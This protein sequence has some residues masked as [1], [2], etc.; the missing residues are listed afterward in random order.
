MSIDLSKMSRADLVQLRKDVETAIIVAES[1]ER[2]EAFK[3]VQD[4]A[5]KFGY[6]LDELTN[7]GKSAPKS[8]G[9]SAPKFRNPEDPEQTWSGLGRKPKWVHDAIANGTN[10]SD[11]EI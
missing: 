9:R 3:A 8:R 7:T 11:L 10:M 5:A 2:K 6:S 1:R 4:A